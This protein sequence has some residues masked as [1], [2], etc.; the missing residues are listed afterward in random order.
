MEAGE[1]RR[2]FAE[3][4]S[5]TAPEKEIMVDDVSN[6]RDRIKGSPATMAKDTMTCKTPNPKHVKHEAGAARSPGEPPGPTPNKKVFSTL[7]KGGY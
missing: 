6:R 3:N 1:H 2:K 4:I 7:A 5:S